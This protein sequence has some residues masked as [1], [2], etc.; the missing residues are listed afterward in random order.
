M[1]GAAFPAFAIVPVVIGRVETAARIPA[2]GHQR[3]Y[4]Y[5]IVTE[6][7][8]RM[9]RG[10]RTRMPAA[11][12]IGLCLPLAATAAI[13]GEAGVQEGRDSVVL[14]HGLGRTQ[15]SMAVLAQRLKRAGY[16][17]TSV[18]YDSRR[19]SLAEHVETLATEVSSCCV[20]ASRV[21]FVGHSLGALVIRQYL[22]DS[23]L[24][25]LGRVVLLAPPNRGSEVADWLRE[26]PFGHLLGPAGKALGT[27]DRDI[28]A[29][30]PLPEYEV[31]IIA[32]N[33]SLNPI[34][35]ALIP[36]PDDGMVGIGHTRIEG[37]PIIVVPASHT[38]LMNSRFSAEAVISFLRT[39]TFPEVPDG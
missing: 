3:N 39:G 2:Y 14:M 17:V 37:V 12:L 30:L 31:G 8:D 19:G 21:H 34:G 6:G 25:A 23:P 26:L 24:D 36:G 11:L 9:A 5:L 13:G 29:N 1:T 33:R 10:L 38:F 28:P 15:T 18:G 20:T 4:E 7:R 22:A 16:N 32:G 35:S 27:S